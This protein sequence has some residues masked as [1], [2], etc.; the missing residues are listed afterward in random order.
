MS[1]LY[2]IV[3]LGGPVTDDELIFF[4]SLWVLMVLVMLIGS[5]L[6]FIYEAANKEK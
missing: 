2:V 1:L 6:Y 3:M 5:V 4:I